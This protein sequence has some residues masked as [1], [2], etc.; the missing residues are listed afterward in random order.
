[1]KISTLGE[2]DEIKEIVSVSFSD[3]P[4]W[5]YETKKEFDVDDLIA[6]IDQKIA[7]LEEEERKKKEKK[8]QNLDVIDDIGE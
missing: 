3:A 2:A 1:M 8:E 6:K 4:A 7:E 5:L